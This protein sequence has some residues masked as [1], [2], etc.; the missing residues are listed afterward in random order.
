MPQQ[1][2]LAELATIPF[3]TRIS[4]S[5]S[6]LGSP[7]SFMIE[8]NQVLVGYEGLVCLGLCI[9]FFATSIIRAPPQDMGAILLMTALITSR[10]SDLKSSQLMSVSVVGL[11]LTTFSPQQLFFMSLLGLSGYIAVTNEGLLQY[12]SQET[13]NGILYGSFPD[14]VEALI[15]SHD[16]RPPLQ[17]Q[18]H[19]SSA[20]P[21]GAINSI[22]KLYT[23]RGYAFASLP[24]SLRWAL[25]PKDLRDSYE[26]R[27]LQILAHHDGDDDGL[28][29]MG[30]NKAI[31][32]VEDTVTSAVS[33]ELVW[34]SDTV[35]NLED[36]LMHHP[37]IWWAERLTQKSKERTTAAFSPNHGKDRIGILILLSA[38]VFLAASAK[39]PLGWFHLRDAQFAC[40]P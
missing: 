32:K 10:W 25:V 19:A 11:L 2:T 22:L 29:T 23:K 26:A 9:T 33:K 4:S 16:N 27:R 36:Y 28:I 5:S 17:S 31:E 35:S 39:G 18:T 1:Q 20:G 21:W 14:A 30:V 12:C 13:L 40:K 8:A 24:A 6:L 37:I 34:V 38:V 7:E 3:S 15:Q